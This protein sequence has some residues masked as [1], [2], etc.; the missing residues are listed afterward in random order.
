MS[1]PVISFGNVSKSFA[2]VPVLRQVSFELAA[3]QSLGLAGE[4]GAG[5]TTLLKCMLDFCSIDDGRILVHGMASGRPEARRQLA[6]L[7]ERFVPPW[8]LTGHEFIRFMLE[9]ART[10]CAEQ[11]IGAMLSGLGL[12]KASLDRPVRT[13][14]KGMTQMLGL[15]A[16]F[17]TGRELYVL[18]EPMSGLDPG[19]RARVK[20]ILRSLRASGR[21]LLFTS[22]SLADVEEICDHMVVLHRGA[23]AF[24]GSPQ[25]LCERHGQASLERAFLKCLEAGTHGSKF[26]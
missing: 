25:E 12:P 15:A 2:G 5:K 1:A 23:V 6:Y 13:Y 4:N 16:C 21:T 11:D 9:L 7:P 8:Y 3:G 20:D 22:H 17:L 24:H 26:G 10:E 19:A 18:D 14:S